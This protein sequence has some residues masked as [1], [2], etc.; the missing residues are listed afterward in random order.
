MIME[1]N[2]DFRNIKICQRKKLNSYSQ[3]LHKPIKFL[4]THVE[5]K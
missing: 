5:W 3:C 2:D 1:I 4:E